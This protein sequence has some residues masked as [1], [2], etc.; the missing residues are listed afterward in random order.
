VS[1]SPRAA[2]LR[3]FEYEHAPVFF[4]RT[5]SRNVLRELL[6]RREAAGR[7]FVLVLGA[8]GSGK[9]SLVNAGLLPDLQRPGVIGQVGL[10]RWG[11][12][13]PSDDRGDLLD[14]LAAAILSA[15][16][17]PELAGL[18]YAPQQLGAL[19]REAPSQAAL[20]IRQRLAAA[21]AA[22]RLPET[23]EARLVVAASRRAV[24]WRRFRLTASVI[25][26]MIALPMIA[27]L[28]WAAIVWAGVRAV[29][30]EMAFVPIPAGC[31]EMG[32]PDSEEGRY[33]NEGPVHQVRAH[34]WT[35]K[36][37]PMHPQD[38]DN[39][40]DERRGGSIAHKYSP[41]T[42]R[43]VSDTRGADFTRNR[44]RVAR[45]TIITTRASAKEMRRG[46]MKRI[47]PAAGKRTW[48]G[49]T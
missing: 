9:S 19:L 48:L 1:G 14:A 11:V 32:S 34:N 13:R 47:P 6:A 26:A 5:R 35:A 43:P 24:Q 2:P 21:G 49:G 38:D 12:L 31:F 8:S 3:S 30:A 40:Q 27:G 18:Q 33:P 42:V 17:L 44:F 22:A 37:R 41:K 45:R 29:E 16:A 15:T 20:P 25:G 23:A 39:E 28:V 10:V 36:A 7:A 4:G 46:I